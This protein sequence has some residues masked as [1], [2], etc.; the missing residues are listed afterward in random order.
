MDQ[1]LTFLPVN[2]F[3]QFSRVANL[4][5]LIIAALQLIPGLSPTPWITTVAPLL[6]VLLLNGAK[7]PVTAASKFLSNQRGNPFNPGRLAPS[8]LFVVIMHDVLANVTLGHRN[9]LCTP[10]VCDGGMHALECDGSAFLCFDRRRN[11]EDHK[12]LNSALMQEV[13]DDVR[14][15]RSDSVLNRRLVTVLRNGDDVRARW[16]DLRVGDVVKVPPRPV[17]IA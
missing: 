14:R 16:Q 11:E 6:F 5:F 3:Q 2:L 13:L 1:V 9:A 17:C 10:N 7:V 15:H 4:Y 8:R 12:V